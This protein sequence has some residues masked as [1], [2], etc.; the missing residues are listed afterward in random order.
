MT[1]VTTTAQMKAAEERSEQ[2]G[3]TRVTLMQNAARQCFEFIKR[4]METACKRFVIICGSGNN[5]GDG[6]ELASLLKE[7]G[8]NVTVLLTHTL[9][10]TDT[11][12]TC[13]EQHTDKPA[14]LSCEENLNAAKDI[15]DSAEVMIDCVFGTGFHGELPDTAA[16]LFAYANAECKALKIAVD[17]PSG[18]NGDSGTIAEN[19]FRP[20]ITLVLGAMKTGLLNHPCCEYCGETATL[21]IGITDDCYTEY[22]AVF[23]PPSITDK[24]PP[25][26]AHANKGVFGKLLNVAG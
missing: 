1:F 14:I 23:T 16:E 8:S 17:I 4:R 10:N 12:R 20:D 3:V 22:E 19:A 25:R 21:D 9:P 26:P 5:G 6:I 15:L 18:I 7:D 24:L 2:K 11:A 13:M